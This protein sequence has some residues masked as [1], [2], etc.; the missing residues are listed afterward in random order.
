MEKKKEL[1]AICTRFTYGVIEKRRASIYVYL[2][3][4]GVRDDVDNSSILF[5]RRALALTMS[6]RE[7]FQIIPCIHV[8]SHIQPKNYLLLWH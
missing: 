8:C 2:S 1:N 7:L 4:Y 6:E 3:W 5:H